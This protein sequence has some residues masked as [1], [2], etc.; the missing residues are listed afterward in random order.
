MESIEGTQ[1]VPAAGA[2]ALRPRPAERGLRSFPFPV[3]LP[4]LD[5]ALTLL[6]SV[7]AV[8]LA[9][10]LLRPTDPDFWWHL[11]TGRLIVESGSVP[12]S[13]P[14]SFTAQ[15]KDWV[16]H[17]WLAEVLIYALQWLGGY[18]LAAVAFSAASIAALAVAYRTALSFGL[19][20]WPAVGLFIWAGAMTIIYWTVRPQVLTWLLFAVFIALCVEHKR[21]R[22]RLWLL[23]ALMVAWANLHLGHAFGLGVLG[24]YFLSQV[25][26]TRLWRE[27]RDWRSPALALAAC[28]AATLLTP[29]PGEL[30]LYPLNYL[31]PGNANLALI[32]EW[33]SPDFHSLVFAPLAGALLF[34]ATIGVSGKRRDV[35]LMLLAVVFGFLALQSVRNQP[36]F[37]IVFMVVAGARL[38]ELL[39]RPAGGVKKP[40]P[41]RIAIN[42]FALTVV[43]GISVMV[44][45]GSPL[46]QLRETARTDG[47]HGYPAQGA[48]FLQEHYPNARV[49]NE[50][51]WGGYLINAL[52]P[53]R[54]FIDGRSDFFGDELMFQYRD[55][56]QLRPGWPDVFRRYDIEVVIV[57]KDSPLAARLDDDPESWR[58]VF[59][60][61]V[62]AVFARGDIAQR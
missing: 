39:P 26:E 23:P 6:L 16:A 52:Y 46:S 38:A 54:L 45:V 31:K 61:P 59:T 33:H 60:G 56:K 43:C 5:G 20:R 12:T 40:P 24:L 27:P 51:H 37:A 28:L 4:V 14:F 35:F 36:L 21:G 13:D 41:G 17:E 8:L 58:R 25:L 22:N 19:Q 42:A 49:F 55:V 10:S 11:R 2:K 9:F 1:E 50:Y 34:L 47:E 18:G 7:F 30:L 29:H 53:Q 44:A 62:E 32:Q 15:G 48:A 57:E 3:A